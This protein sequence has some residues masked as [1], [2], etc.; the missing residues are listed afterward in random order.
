WTTGSY[1]YDGSGN[2]TGMG[3]SWFLYDPVS[4][5]KSATLYT[6]VTGGGTEKKQSYAYDAFG[7]IQSISGTSGRATPT[8]SGTNRLTGGVYDSA[9]NLTSWNGNYYEYDSFNQL[10]RII[11]GGQE[12]IYL[13]TADD[14]RVWH[15]KIGAN[16]RFDRWT[17]RDLS[18]KVLREYTATGYVWSVAEDY[19]YRRGM[20]LAAEASSGQ[21]HFHLDHLGTPRL[22]TDATGQQ[23]AYHVYYPFGEEATAFDQDPERM[24]FA[25]HERDLASLKGSAD[26]LDYVHARHFSML[27]G[28]FLSTDPARRCTPTR[29]PQILNRYSYAINIPLKYKDRTGA[30]LTLVYD[31]KDSNL[32]ELE[33]QK[34]MLNVR[35]IFMRAGVENVRNVFRHGGKVPKIEGRQHKVVRLIFKPIVTR[36]GKSTGDPVLGRTPLVPTKSEVS[37]EFAQQQQDAK[38]IQ[39]SNTA[40]H[41]AGHQVRLWPFDFAASGASA[42]E[43]SIMEQGV[44]VEVLGE[45]LRDFSEGDAELLREKLNAKK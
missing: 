40:A 17:L 33:Q 11:A 13:Y 3:T 6:G 22:I 18:G 21:R 28:R 19:I 35:R 23:V 32:G 29:K 24:K 20:L 26:D 5:L 27:T 2:V 43:G 38:I 8:N 31:F 39:I 10:S 16:P 44:P 7:N 15:F 14:E 25:G 30:D 12:W 42:E 41:E 36:G 4:R 1:G 37:T 9:G 34:V 45:E